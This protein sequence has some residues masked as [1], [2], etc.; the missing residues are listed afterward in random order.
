MKSFNQITYKNKYLTSKVLNFVLVILFLGSMAYYANATTP[1]P[2]HP[3]AEVGDGVFA[4]TNNQT[5]VRTYTFPDASTT[6]LTT[7]SAVTV[8]QGGTGIATV[9]QGD[10]LYGSSADTISALAKDTNSTRYLS[11]TG[12]SN[13]PA[14]SLVDLTNG[15]TGTLPVSSGGTG[16]TTLTA[17]SVILG[18]GTSAPTFVAPG[19]SGN[20][21][22]SNG[23]TWTSSAPAGSAST[24][25]VVSRSMMAT[26]AVSAVA[27]SSLTVRKTAL[28]EVPFGI[29]VNSLTYNVAAVTTAGT[30]RICVYNEAGDTKLIDVTD[31][32]TAGV[33][34]V[35]VGSVD[36]TAAKYYVAMGCATTC[37]NTI[38]MFTS[39]ATAWINGA[40]TP[41]TSKKYEGDTTHISGTC[42][43]TLPAITGA[44]SRAPVIRFD[45]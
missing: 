44:N 40:S 37:S 30:Y 23:T 17:D 22:T 29:T 16:L 13:N 24:T 4:V 28:F 20:V 10:L 39:T 25:T 42:N 18:N 32:P 11:N 34:N 1:N 43:D 12:T 21:L 36:L 6:V 7:N 5:G 19:T 33:N 41:G 3:W 2:G 45:N 27:N 15:I 8:P 35:A 31:T 26:G 14:W 38:S 9:D